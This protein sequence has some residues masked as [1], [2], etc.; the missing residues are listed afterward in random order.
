MWGITTFVVVCSSLVHGS[1]I[2]LFAFGKKLNK[3]EV[4]IAMKDVY[5]PGVEPPLIKVVSPEIRLE[6]PSDDN[7]TLHRASN[8][9]TGKAKRL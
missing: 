2:A 6:A 4:N 5:E 3:F 8:S 1:G 9:S 7:A